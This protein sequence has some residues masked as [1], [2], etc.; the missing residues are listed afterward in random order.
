MDNAWNDSFTHF[1]LTL[2]LFATYKTVENGT[3]LWWA[4]A[5]GT[6]FFAAMTVVE[7]YKVL[8]KK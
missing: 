5:I 8:F 4:T 2:A 3:S 1:G 6:L 7:V